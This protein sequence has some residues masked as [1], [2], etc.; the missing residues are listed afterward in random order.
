LKTKHYSERKIW[1]DSL[2]TVVDRELILGLGV[3]GVAG[4]LGMI[5]AT[6]WGIGLSPDSAVY[7]GGARS[8]LQGSGF[9]S[10]TDDG[11]FAPIV[12]F[13]PLY[14]LGLVALA[15]FSADLLQTA[16]WFAALLFACNIILT[17]TLGFA[18]S[19]SAPFSLLLGLFALAAL[20]MVQVHTMAWSEPLFIASQLGGILVLLLYFRNGS[21][22][23][24]ILA[25]AIFGGGV[26]VRYAG[27]AM[28]LAGVTGL[29]LLSEKP[30]GGR[31][32]DTIIFAVIGFLPMTAWLV[33]NEWATASLVN[34]SVSIHPISGEQIAAVLHVLTGWLSFSWLMS[35]DAT[36]VSLIVLILGGATCLSL[37]ALQKN[38]TQLT[39]EM[40]VF[41]AIHFLIIVALSYLFTLLGSISFLDAWVPVDTRLLSPVYVPLLVVAL[42]FCARL[43][44][45][46]R[47]S[48]FSR[49]VMAL[50]L[51]LTLA[52]L[53][54]RSI[55]WLEFSYHD[56]VGYAAGVWRNSETLAKLDSLPAANGIY[57]NA[58]DVLYILRGTPAAMM[59][60]KIDPHT[61]RPNPQFASEMNQLTR[62]LKEDR[63][64][65]VFFSQVSWRWYL[66][67]A[68]EIE[69]A[70]GMR[71]LVRT[72]DGL[73]FMAH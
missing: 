46:S 36:S 21:R 1:F 35:F 34:R 62:R 55:N 12:H 7:I 45:D 24:L 3:F 10:P 37:Q 60:R 71:P 14:S 23:G 56:G 73:I 47:L 53:T 30:W 57:S 8:L 52:A 61:S 28:L 38:S 40:D 51:M 33:R 16:R 59:P 72:K 27:L 50:C 70:I 44:R 15:V 19:R 6:P 64:I 2:M 5:A 13:P 69:K 20:P 63:T 25:A 67:S 43:W 17:G 31:I 49:A 9:S 4:A 54:A 65:L 68:D 48:G 32:I 11:G 58:P 41:R 39:E 18:V 42:F 66:P 26:L 22:R 29:L